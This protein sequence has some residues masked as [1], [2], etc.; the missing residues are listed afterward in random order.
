MDNKLNKKYRSFR[1]LLISLILSS[2]CPS[3]CYQIF[4]NPSK[5]DIYHS[6]D[7]FSTSINNISN[8]T[9]IIG[10]EIDQLI[11]SKKLEFNVFTDGDLNITELLSPTGEI[12]N[13]LSLEGGIFF[14]DAGSPR[15]PIKN[16][17]VLIPSGYK[18]E[19]IE[20]NVGKTKIIILDHAIEPTQEQ[21]P[22][23]FNITQ[24]YVFDSVIYN[25]SDPF[26]GI[27]YSFEGIN[28]FRGYKILLL[29]LYPVQY[30]PNS[31]KISVSEDMII[32]IDLMR[33]LDYNKNL[34]LRN[35]RK[36]EEKVMSIVIN[37]EG[38]KSYREMVDFESSLSP[39]LWD[40]VI[41]T[42]E[43]LKNSASTYTFQYLANLK[44]LKGIKTIIV[45]VEEIYANYTGVDNQ[46]KIRNFIIDA[47]S[48]WGIEYVL[49]GGDGDGADVGG[50][51]GDFIIPARNLYCP[52]PYG[53]D[54]IP[55]DLYYSALDGTW[56]DDNY[57]LWGEPGEDDLFAEVYVGR[58]PV[59]SEEELSNFI[60]KT[61]AHEASIDEDY[62]SRALMI[63]EDLGWHPVYGS[64]YKN[65]ILYGSSNNGYTTIGFPDEFNVSTL[66]EPPHWSKANLLALLNDRMH[67]INH[68]GHSNNF[69]LMKLNNDDIDSLLTNENYF[70]VYSQGCYAGAFDNR[71]SDDDDRQYFDFDCIVEHF[72]TSPYGAFAFIANSR[73]GWGDRYGT[74]GASQFFDRE[75]FDAIFG[76]GILEI[77]RANQDSKEDCIGFLSQKYVRWCYYQITLF[78]DPTA[79]ILLQP[80]DN[81][82][83]LINESIS[84]ST[85]YQNTSLTFRVTYEDADNNKPSFMRVVINGTDYEMEKQDP[86][87]YD[88]TDGCNYQL[89][90]FLQPAIANYCYYMECSDGEYR[91]KT[92]E[93]CDIHIYYSNQNNPSLTEVNVHPMIGTVNITNFNYSI[94]Y[95]DPDNNAPLE[96]NLTINSSSYTMTKYDILDN[97]YIDG[98]LYVYSTILDDTGTYIY[99]FSCFDGIYSAF[100][101]TSNGPTVENLTFPFKGM[102]LNYSFEIN[103]KFGLIKF[104]YNNQEGSY[105]NVDWMDYNSELNE[106]NIIGKWK[107]DFLTRLMIPISGRTFGYAYTPLWI[108]KDIALGD[109]IRIAVDNE[110]DHDFLVS[111]EI[112]CEFPGIG[113]IDLWEVT[114]LTVS[115]GIAWY[116][117][118]TGLLL[119]G[120]YFY[121]GYYYYTF[122]FISTNVDIEELGDIE[123]IA[124]F[125]SDQTI[126]ENQYN[127]FTFTGRRGNGLLFFDWDFGDESPHSQEEN[128]MHQYRSPGTY[129]VSLNLTD[130]DG[131][132]DYEQK[133]DFILV[134]EDIDPISDFE[135]NATHI[136]VGEYVQFTFTGSEGNAP[137]HYYWN[138]GDGTVSFIKKDPVHQYNSPGNYIVSLRVTDSNGDRI[139]SSKY[140][141]IIVDTYVPIVNFNSNTTTIFDGD[142]I[143]F[144]FIGF[145]GDGPSI[146]K[147]DFGDGSPFSNDP[148]PTHQ[149]ISPGNYTVSLNVTDT[150][151]DWDYEEKINLIVVIEDIL[152][153]AD[154]YVNTT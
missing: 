97:N 33:V 93:C 12:Y 26:P 143:Q 128:P 2:L 146:F 49:L 7:S 16:L 3:Y 109:H 134:E 14:G 69:N 139:T 82:P 107:E 95:S 149:Y 36:D 152:P 57:A 123:P 38:I 76:E 124:D 18:I 115:G 105:F 25:S 148:N 116:E 21:V 141:L 129:T 135:V 67:V 137:A 136:F 147:W 110:G 85:G 140:E 44:N 60:M 58:A 102:F 144:S 118:S 31:R 142:I 154:F 5:N 114:D 86:D 37:P 53:D 27:Y 63:G 10:E 113:L 87:D 24:E 13:R 52:S 51:S 40:Y 127:Q 100:T 1:L 73:Y 130:S 81:P 125:Q 17:K 108:H 99:S 75:F 78:G 54:F 56:N 28:F 41:I 151:G 9:D 66:Y 112:I 94:I 6:L 39:I 106:W 122:E 19:N 46:E 64:D 42:N 103:E 96:V 70:F 77:G 30:F 117:K 101:S 45:N 68:L 89:S 72:I 11:N 35:L 20:V 98:C 15:L 47:Y 59:D 71:G 22:I 84:A 50:E 138:F 4:Y 80:N 131:D 92:I 121:N 111:D 104:Q 74:N 126:V 120:T 119:N 153:I 43:M 29:N 90:T 132:W 61:I 79:S 150:D 34:F 23:G 55:S 62:L 65:E 32:S 48:K 88:Y 83:T 133:I 91:I 145:D 8:K